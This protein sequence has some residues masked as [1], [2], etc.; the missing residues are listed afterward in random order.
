MAAQVIVT[1]KPNTT[2][3]CEQDYK[4]VSNTFINTPA[5]QKTMSNPIDREQ[6]IRMTEG[7]KQY[8]LE[9]GD[10]EL[11]KLLG[12]LVTVAK[13]YSHPKSNTAPSNSGTRFDSDSIFAV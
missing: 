7:K 4:S 6:F 11:F 13:Q 9:N 5:F 10:D 2:G 8:A 3:N 12:S 1:V